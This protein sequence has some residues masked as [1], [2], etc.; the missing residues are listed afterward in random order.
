ML[1]TD[2]GHARQIIHKSRVR[3]ASARHH[4]T[5]VLRPV[6]HCRR[7]R[8]AG[9]VPAR[10]FSHLEDPDIQHARSEPNRRMHIRSARQ[11]PTTGRPPATASQSGVARRRE[12]GKV[13]DR[14]PG[15]KTTRGARRPPQQLDDPPQR[16]VLSIDRARPSLPDPGEH[17][18]RAGHKIERHRRTRRRRRDIREIHRIILR[19]RRRQQDIAKH[20]QRL[21]T[22]NPRRRHRTTS[23]RRKL[24]RRTRRRL[25]IRRPRNPQGR[26]LH[27]NPDQLR[28]IAPHLVHHPARALAVA[29]EAVGIVVRPLAFGSRLADA[30]LAAHGPGSVR[31]PLVIVDGRYSLQRPALRAVLE[32]IEVVRGTHQTLPAGCVTLASTAQATLHIPRSAAR[33]L[34]SSGSG[35]DRSPE[36]L[37]NC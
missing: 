15:D 34:R 13:P 8:L 14:P 12:R 4:G 28:L 3:R 20:A 37:G 26:P 5:D 7:Q 2:R 1:G 30:A 25:R 32:C 19:P 27:Q 21:D 11:P 35:E 24:R 31:L 17:V 23:H 33:G 36:P 6:R 22:P 29:S 9:E 16:L 18:R 10:V